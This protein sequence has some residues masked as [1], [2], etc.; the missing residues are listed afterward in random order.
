ML[1]PT[2][3]AALLLAITGRATAVV[4]PSTCLLAAALARA[5]EVP[6][7]L[8]ADLDAFR[9]GCSA[10]GGVSA[11]ERCLVKAAAPPLKAAPPQPAVSMKAAPRC[12]RHQLCRNNCTFTHQ[13]PPPPPG[14]PDHHL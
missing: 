11:L 7:A 3:L 6:D 12:W 9:G 4:S 14:F 2:L 1:R 5:S 8:R 10:Q 13:P